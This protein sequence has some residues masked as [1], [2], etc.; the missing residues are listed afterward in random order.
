MRENLASVSSP[1]MAFTDC[2]K[3]T[4]LATDKGIK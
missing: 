2:M 1:N 4:E 3:P